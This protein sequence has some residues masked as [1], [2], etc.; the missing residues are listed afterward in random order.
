[1][2]SAYKS[3]TTEFWSAS[4]KSFIKI[5][6]SKGPEIEPLGTPQMTYAGFERLLFKETRCVL[7]DR[8]DAK[9]DRQFSSHL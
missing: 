7:F 2:S 8:Y 3:T 1:M 9:H 4:G 5:K 6:N